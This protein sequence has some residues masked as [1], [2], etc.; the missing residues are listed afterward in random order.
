VSISPTFYGQLFH[1]NVFL[2]LSVL[3]VWVYNIL[4]KVNWQKS[5]PRNVGEID[6]KKEN[7]SLLMPNIK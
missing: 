1:R 6:Y 4:V 2:R 3:T 7:G 5:R